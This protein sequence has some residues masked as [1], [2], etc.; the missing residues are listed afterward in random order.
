MRSLCVVVVFA[1]A[2][3]ALAAAPA[4]GDKALKQIDD[5]IGQSKIDKSGQNWR[6][7]LP[8]PPV[9]SFEPGKS[10][11]ARMETNKGTMLIKFMP[12]VAPMHVTSFLYL[13]RLG[14]YDGVVFHRVIPGFMAQGGDPTGTGSG[15]PGYMYEGE[16]KPGVKHDRGGLLSMAHAGAGTDGS[17]FFLTF[18]PTPWLDGKH[19][20][21]GEVVEGKD[22]LQ[23]LEAAGS[24]SGRTSE[25]LVMNKV[26]VEV[27]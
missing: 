26:T 8:K 20:I 23:K 15:G 11:F 9:A 16:F 4:T 6:T 5:F 25:K 18:V 27:R 2:G 12:E 21:F 7:S 14:F 13:T 3:L 17:Q 1:V 22:V 10:Y 19:T 24:S